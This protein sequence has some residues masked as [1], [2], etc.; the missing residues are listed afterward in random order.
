MKSN[1]NKVIKFTLNQQIKSKSFRTSTIMI[2][3]FVFIGMSLIN[4]IPAYQKTK[5]KSLDALSTV[6]VDIDKIYCINETEVDVDLSM[7]LSPL[8]ENTALENV[9]ESRKDFIEKFK[10]T[11]EKAVTVAFLKVNDSYMVEIIKPLNG[12]VDNEDAKKL[13]KKIPDTIAMSILARE[14]AAIERIQEFLSPIH[15]EVIKADEKSKSIEEIVASTI[16]PLM[17]LLLLFYIIYFYGFTVANSIVAEKTSRIMELLLTKVKPIELIFGKCIA[18]GILAIIQFFSIGIVAVL[19][20][21]FS[22]G[23]VYKF[24]DESAKLV[25]ISDL[26][27]GVGFTDICIFLIFFILGYILYAL[28]NV[29]PGCTV[30]KSEDLQTALMPMSIVSLAGFYLGYGAAMGNVE[31]TLSKYA[32]YIPISSPF[33]LPSALLTHEIPIFNI[34]IS[35]LVLIVT[36][37]LVLIFTSRVYTIAL[38]HTGNRLKFK[39]LIEIFK[40]NKNS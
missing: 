38:L 16:L 13:S 17:V 28:L 15:S 29:L 19:G 14:G 35:L 21:L 6:E 31:S 23:I 9:T 40:S 3:L 8:I 39:D 25:K 26:F 36:I 11:E 4:I 24:I 1:L 20:Y 2:L 5:D 32:L 12:L 37:A 33:Y 27:V 34:F 30:T 10:T 18:M 7:I 22:E